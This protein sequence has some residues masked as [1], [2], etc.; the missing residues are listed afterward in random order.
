MRSRLDEF[1]CGLAAVKEVAEN[2][3]LRHPATLKCDAVLEHDGQQLVDARAELT[4][5]RQVECTLQRVGAQRRTR[6]HRGA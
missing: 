1:L 6:E 3:A 4:A 5:R 2:L